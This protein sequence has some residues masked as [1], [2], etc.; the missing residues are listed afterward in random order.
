MDRNFLLKKNIDSIIEKISVFFGDPE[1]INKLM[2]AYEEDKEQRDINDTHKQILSLIDSKEELMSVLENSL[3]F[4]GDDPKLV[5]AGSLKVFKILKDEVNQIFNL[6]NKA[7]HEKVELNLVVNTDLLHTAPQFFCDFIMSAVAQLDLVEISLM[8]EPQDMPE[9]LMINNK[10]VVQIL[11]CQNGDVTA[12]Y[13]RD[14]K[15]LN[16]YRKLVNR[17]MSP[18]GGLLDPVMP[19][20]LRLTNVQ[21]DSYSDTRQ[22]LF[23]NEAPALL[24]P[25]DLSEYLIESAKDPSDKDYLMRLMNVFKTR[26][27]HANIKLAVYSSVMNEYIKNGKISI[28]NVPQQ[29]TAEQIKDHLKYL[30]QVMQT[31]SGF[32]VYLIRDTVGRRQKVKEVPSLFVDTRSVSIENSRTKPNKNYHFSMD[33]EVVTIFQEY[34]EIILQEPNCIMLKPEDLDRFL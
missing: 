29:F 28:G 11:M 24:F 17:N 16:I 27:S 34:F 2:A 31:N 22:W 26:T 1:I 9:F 13:G 20:D 32:E 3:H 23:Y 8:R 25:A 14:E 5:M 12:C 30:Q 33:P 19:A 10:M 7:N 18:G 21:L 15:V 6:L 4:D